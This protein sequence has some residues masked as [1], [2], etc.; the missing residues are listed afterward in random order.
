MS[1]KVFIATN[2]VKLAHGKVVVAFFSSII[3]F[4]F[5]LIATAD[6][7]VIFCVV[8]IQESLIFK[9]L[10]EALII[11]IGSTRTSITPAPV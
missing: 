7:A 2:F 5:S 4:V 10:L 1:K 8:P 11:L 3:S 6:F 9:I